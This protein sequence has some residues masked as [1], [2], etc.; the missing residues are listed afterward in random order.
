MG[1]EKPLCGYWAAL[2]GN[3]TDKV[4]KKHIEEQKQDGP[5]DEFRV[6]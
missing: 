1:D 3:V 5:D 4:W 6:L 2:S